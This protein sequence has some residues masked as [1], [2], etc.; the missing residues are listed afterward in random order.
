M[1]GSLTG[2]QFNQYGNPAEVCAPVEIAPPG[3]PAAGEVT[4]ALEYAPINPSDLVYI[5]G[6]YGVKAK[7]FPT[8][9]GGEGVARVTAVGAGVRHL[10]EGDR[11]LTLL[12]G[13]MGSWQSLVNRSA[14]TLFALPADLD[15]VQASMI[16]VN[17]PTAL[18]MLT[19][20]YKLEP[21]DWIAQNAG[22][23]AVGQ[24]VIKLCR[25]YGWRSAS[26]VRRE[27]LIP[28]LTA[29]GADLVVVDGPDF[30][31]QIREATGGKGVRLGI[32]AIGGDSTRQLAKTVRN[33]G[34]VVNYGGL[35]GVPCTVDFAELIFR[36]VALRGYWLQRFLTQ[37]GP[38]RIIE[39]YSKLAGLVADGTLAVEVE[40]IYPLSE[41][42]AALAHA[43]QEGRTGKILL[44]G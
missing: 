18:I 24:L 40:K 20:Y 23:S 41:C 8:F 17:P 44:A 1:T 35:S 15:P 37:G 10:K 19:E 9:A 11:V 38:Q 30:P 3:D 22:N 42:K 14:A 33:G 13:V 6:N 34:T 7:S 28:P 26:I 16:G 29:I 4:L 21:G 36:D 12:T 5:A 43:A 25:K 27:S 32:D 31:Q 2:V 39:T